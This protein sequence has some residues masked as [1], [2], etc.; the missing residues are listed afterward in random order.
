M[1]RPV[2]CPDPRATAPQWQPYV[3][4]GATRTER[5]R[6]LAQ[7]PETMRSRIEA[8]VRTVFAL[9]AKAARRAV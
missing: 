3:A 9:R 7:A 2:S 8:H 4:D 5:A 1:S 6:R